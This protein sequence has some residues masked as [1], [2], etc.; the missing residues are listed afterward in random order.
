MERLGEGG[1]PQGDKRCNVPY[2]APALRAL[3]DAFNAVTWHLYKQHTAFDQTFSPPGD[4]EGLIRCL[5]Y[6]QKWREH[7][8]RLLLEGQYEGG[9]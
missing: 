6:A 7:Q 9:L 1:K 8:I 3:A 2:Y 5:E 4:A